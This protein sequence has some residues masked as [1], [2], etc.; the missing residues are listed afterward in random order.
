MTLNGAIMQLAEIWNHPMCPV[1][2]KPALN[3][4]IETISE[5]EEE[6]IETISEPEEKP[7][8]SKEVT[9]VAD[10]AIP[11]ES[12][13]RQRAVAAAKEPVNPMYT[14]AATSIKEIETVSSLVKSITKQVQD[15]IAGRIEQLP[16]QYD[17]LPMTVRVDIN[18][19]DMEKLVEKFKEG[20]AIFVERNQEDEWL[21]VDLEHNQ[22]PL[23]EWVLVSSEEHV[24]RDAVVV[25]NGKKIWYHEGEILEDDR[26]RYP[27]EPYHPDRN[28]KKEKPC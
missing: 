28:E 17:V 7:Q 6:L 1:I 11:D 4:V 2:F 16:P 15:A 3:K 26:W 8:P 21:P 25:R 22:P 18:E 19:E 20:G 12:I 27:P 24:T 5:L 10:H 13:S 23:E 9:T 14:W